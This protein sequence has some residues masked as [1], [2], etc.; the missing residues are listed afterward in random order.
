MVGKPL[1]IIV[2][3]SGTTGL[4]CTVALAKK[5]H[6][7]TCIESGPALRL[8]GGAYRLGQNSI[9]VLRSL[10]VLE[11]LEKS[12]CRKSPG[13]RTRRYKDGEVLYTLTVDTGAN[14]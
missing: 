5:G 14:T 9:K 12:E 2:V 11:E 10:G 1:S 7:V 3:G 13:F 8:S 4:C 6:K